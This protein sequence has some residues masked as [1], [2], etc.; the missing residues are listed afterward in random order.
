MLKHQHPVYL[1]DRTRDPY[2]KYP[3]GKYKSLIYLFKVINLMVIRITHHYRSIINLILTERI[4]LYVN[5]FTL[6]P[7]RTSLMS[8]WT[9]F[10]GRKR[11]SNP[12]SETPDF[13][14]P[15]PV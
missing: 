10:G 7:R 2:K 8:D 13:A 15:D 11:L 12:G 4:S 14:F 1:T 9:I 3:Q 5:I 6:T